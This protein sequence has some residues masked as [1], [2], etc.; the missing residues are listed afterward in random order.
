VTADTES[1]QVKTPELTSGNRSYC[2]DSITFHAPMAKLNSSSTVDT[3]VS[4]S[5]RD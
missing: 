3:L 5:N 2:V 1:G 4:A